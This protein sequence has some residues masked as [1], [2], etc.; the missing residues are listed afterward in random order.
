MRENGELLGPPMVRT[1]LKTFG[2]RALHSV[3]IDRLVG[4]LES[5]P[6]VIGYHQVVKRFHSH[7][8]SRIPPMLLSTAMLERHLDWLGRRFNFISLDE[9]GRT[10]E[11]GARFKRPVATIT[12]DDGY[13]DVYHNA[14]PVL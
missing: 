11:G 1:L 10:L 8:K 14:F 9:L 3:G 4:G 13:R 12:F 7:V 6:V 2:S 5:H